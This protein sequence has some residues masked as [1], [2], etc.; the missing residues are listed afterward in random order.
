MSKTSRQ[1]PKVIE[2]F[3]FCL[4]TSIKIPPHETG[5]K[6]SVKIIESAYE[7][8]GDL[9][10]L[11][12]DCGRM[13]GAAC[14]ESEGYMLLFPY[15]RELVEKCDGFHMTQ[16]HLDGYGPVD[17]VTCD[18]YCDRDCRPLSC[19]IFP[20]A[21]KF[22]DGELFVR[23]DPRGRSVCP[24]AHKSILSLDKEFTNIIKK[25]L[26]MLSR[27]DKISRYLKAMSD[28]AD[29]FNDIFA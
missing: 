22:I 13:C 8:I 10:P 23:L 27:D 6:M 4:Y 12:S 17:A 24:L 7:M 26:K 18:G 11:K 14:C 2:L 16:K 9:T 1:L 29:K 25:T 3:G 21:P 15:E 5:D 28:V 20:L 19:R